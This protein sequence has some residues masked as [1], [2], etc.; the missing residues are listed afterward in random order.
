MWGW[1]GKKKKV[2]MMIKRALPYPQ[3][4]RP[5]PHS[6]TLIVLLTD[7]GSIIQPR[8]ETSVGYFLEQN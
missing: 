6:T 3:F 2:E 5:C 1:E 8:F 4:P 7:L